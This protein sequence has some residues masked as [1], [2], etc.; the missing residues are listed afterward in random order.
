M[1]RPKKTYWEVHCVSKSRSIIKNHIIILKLIFLFFSLRKISVLRILIV[2]LCPNLDARR[3]RTA[4]CQ[5]LSEERL[6][7]QSVSSYHITYLNMHMYIPFQEYINSLNIN[8]LTNLEQFKSNVTCK[9]RTYIV[10]EVTETLQQ[11][12]IRNLGF[13]KS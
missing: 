6:M 5:K 13:Y 7:H 4:Y 8:Q 11:M 9:P 2:F 3:T 1:T 12:F 10:K